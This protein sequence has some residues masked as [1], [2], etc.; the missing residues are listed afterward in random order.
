MVLLDISIHDFIAL[1]NTETVVSFFGLLLIFSM[2]VI[3]IAP[4][5]INPWSWLLK[6]IGNAVNKDLIGRIDIL[7]SK[8]DKIDSEAEARDAD[9]RR[10]R[11]LRASNDLHNNAN[12]KPDQEF[13]RQIMSD[14]DEY[15][16]YCKKH[17]EYINNYTFGKIHSLKNKYEFE[18][19]N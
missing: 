6:K 10:V 16:K 2:T 19:M 18:N 12:F 14:I 13:W 17:P 5:R 7:Q 9:T 11:I 15:E 1:K 8:I 3:Q 4:I